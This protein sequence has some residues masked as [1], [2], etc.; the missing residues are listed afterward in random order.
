MHCRICGDPECKLIEEMNSLVAYGID[1]DIL[2]YFHHHN[3]NYRNQ[4]WQCSKG[5]EFVCI[6]FFQCWCGWSSQYPEKNF[7]ELKSRPPTKGYKFSSGVSCLND[8]W[9]ESL[10]IKNADT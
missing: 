8:K 5:H 3:E 9:I 4:K 2:G 10:R 7:V 1:E 6:A